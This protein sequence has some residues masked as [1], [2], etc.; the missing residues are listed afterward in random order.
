MSKQQHTPGP[1]TLNYGQTGKIIIEAE[2]IERPASK[3]IATVFDDSETSRQEA[4]LISKA[5]LIPELKAALQAV[6]NQLNV[7][8][9]GD[10]SVTDSELQASTNAA[11]LLS[12]LKD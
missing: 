12:K 9:D 7:Y 2:T 10:D 4:R 8:L 5:Y 3:H 11:T 6:T 1:W